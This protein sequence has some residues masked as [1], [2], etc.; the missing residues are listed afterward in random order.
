MILVE[1]YEGVA[2][3]H[4]GGKATTHKLLCSSLSCPTLH[5]D[6][7]EYCQAFDICQRA[8]IPNKMDE[9]PLVPEVT[10]TAIDK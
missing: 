10:L 8:G 4:Y 2:G 3:H 6:A 5:K 9:I 7:K 1:A